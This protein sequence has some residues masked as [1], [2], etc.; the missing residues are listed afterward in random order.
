MSGIFVTGDLVS[1][2]KQKRTCQLKK[3]YFRL[4]PLSISLMLIFPGVASAGRH[5]D[6][7]MLSGDGEAVADLSRFEQ[8]SAQLPGK[9]QVDIY[10]NGNKVSTRT[11]RFI[12]RQEADKYASGGAASGSLDVHDDT[13]L[14]AFFTKK[15]LV[16]LGV[17]PA[18]FPALSALHDEQWVSPGRYIPQAYTA[19]DFQKMRLDIS[20]PQAA[21]QNQ[22]HGWIAPEQWD[23]GINAALLNYQFSGSDNSGSYGDSR[24]HYLNLTTGLNLGAWR[25]RDNSTWSD[26][27]SSYEHQRRWQHLNT[28]V[29]RAIIPFRSELTAGDSTTSGD[30]F[31]AFSF[32]GIQLATDDSMYPDTMRGFAPEIKGTANS[33]A[34]VS[35]RQNGNVIYQTYVAAGAFKIN[36]LY[37]V[38]SGGDLEVAITEANGVTRVFTVPYSSVPLLQRQGHLRYGITAG[39]YRSS[40]DRYS[41]PSF[42]QGTLLWGLPHD[43]T[44][45]GGLQIADN[46]R[47]I[48]LGTGL[49]MGRW[50]ALSADITKAYSTLA[51]GSQHSGQSVRFLYGR[52]LIATGT[53]VQLAGYRYSSQGFHTLEETALKSMSGWINDT[54][55]VDAA[56][57]P[58]EPGWS[59]YYN[60]YSSKR[61]RIQANISQRIGNIGS[62]YL[63]GSR[64]TYWRN[65]ATTESLQAGFSS[66]VGRVNYS[67]SYGYS[68]V[69]NQPQADKTIFLSLSV[70]LESWLPH[71]GSTTHHPVWATYNASS[72]SDGGVSHQVGLSG[73]A[74]AEDNLSWTISQGYGKQDGGSGDVGL[75]YQGTYGNASLGYGYSQ[76]YRQIRYGA[77]G[78]MLLHRDGLTLGQPLGATNALVAVPGGAGIPLENGTGIKTDWRGY[79]V[80][81]YVNTYREN[82]VALDVS[83]LDD[84]IDIEDA[85]TRVVPTQG[86]LVRANFIAHSGIRALMTLTYKG[87]PLPFGTTVSSVDGSSSL[88]GDEG[89]VY[90]SGLMQSGEL[91]AKWGRGREQQCTVHY[92]L[93]QNSLHESVVQ[94]RETCR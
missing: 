40:S 84:H 5:F 81:P 28:Y 27:E 61:E 90:L 34:K 86:A 78:S 72:N 64:Q 12:S 2:K 52:S 24:S 50:G 46:Y 71:S 8:G 73:T 67:L 17:N 36:D 68:R 59:S 7:A 41:D 49:D 43:V 38:S 58:V 55:T 75:G 30:V 74:L 76:D 79:A 45:Y 4:A 93:P 53:T 11:L 70:P 22:V 33:N 85:V 69:S 47:A 66:S 26:Y 60:M 14:V 63:T 32:R 19:F 88:T 80:V 23:E 13:G 31:D 29:Q 91:Q 57:R 6:P 48:A 94:A 44:A 82:R 9:Y 83:Q 20:I 77:S 10:L 39:R 54:K 21:L 37:P 65:S 51:D 16:N 89:Q 87:K 3:C 56:G 35:I 42:A 15:D 92:R 25:L 1:K 62:L 18:G